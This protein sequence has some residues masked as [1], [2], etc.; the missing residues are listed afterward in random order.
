MRQYKSKGGLTWALPSLFCSDEMKSLTEIF[1]NYHFA[2]RVES[3]EIRFGRVGTRPAYG[4]GLF[5]ALSD[6]LY[7]GSDKCTIMSQ[8]GRQF[9][10]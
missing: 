9:T 6:V 10:A 8:T 3:A 2:A 7:L 1:S 4:E 5:S